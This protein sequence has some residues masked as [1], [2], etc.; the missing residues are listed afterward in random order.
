MRF[1]S[2]K[3]GNYVDIPWL[4]IPSVHSALSMTRLI[5]SSFSLVTPRSSKPL[6]SVPRWNLP[7]PFQQ[8]SQWLT[9]YIIRF[10]NLGDAL[11][12]HRRFLLSSSGSTATR[13]WRSL[14]WEVL[15][16]MQTRWRGTWKMISK[17]RSLIF[18]IFEMRKRRGLRSSPNF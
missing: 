6:Q 15:L 2:F 10:S 3:V 18:R 1:S 7:S 5:N 17:S 11:V 9:S 16:L 13:V 4:S 8:L 12:H 14:P